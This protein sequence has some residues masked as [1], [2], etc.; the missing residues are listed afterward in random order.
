MYLNKLTNLP[1]WNHCIEIK[2]YAE[3][4]HCVE[5]NTQT[6]WLVDTNLSVDC[7]FLRIVEFD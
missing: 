7:K 6:N 2:N 1:Q 3:M 4:K 5:T